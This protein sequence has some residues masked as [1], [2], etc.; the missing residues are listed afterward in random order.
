MII[1]ADIAHLWAITIGYQACTL[2]FI[3]LSFFS[4][5]SSSRLKA[6]KDITPTKVSS[7]LTYIGDLRMESILFICRT[8]VM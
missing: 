6:L 2:S 4:T 3:N 7:K 8:D 1:L 5:K